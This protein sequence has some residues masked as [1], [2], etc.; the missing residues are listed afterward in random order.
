MCFGVG[1]VSCTEASMTADLLG[2]VWQSAEWETGSKSWEPR[3][4]GTHSSRGYLLCSISLVN[5]L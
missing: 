4:A 3:Q 2:V 1:Q 5:S